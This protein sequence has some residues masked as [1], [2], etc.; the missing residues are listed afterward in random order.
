M[1]RIQPVDERTFKKVIDMKLPP[2]QARFV[3]PNVVSLAQAWLYYESARPMAICDEDEVV[4]FMML[5]WDEGE[6]SVGIWRFM[7]AGEHQRK[8]YGRKAMEAAIRLA[9]DAET[10]DF[11]QLDYVPGNTVARELYHSLGFRENGKVAYG[12]I[13]MTLPLTTQPRV[14]VLTADEDDWDDFAALI[15]AER[16]AGAA[17]PQEFADM[18]SLKKAVA[19]GR[20]TRITIMGNTIG[21][22]LGEAMLIAAES[23]AYLAEAQERISGA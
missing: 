21:L 4:G 16:A 22:A 20:V 8:G 19:D 3:A 5:D 14:G 1:I 10:M 17:I 6:R 12:E 18:D 9:R 11:V 23:R 15:E 2:D 13:V 7:I